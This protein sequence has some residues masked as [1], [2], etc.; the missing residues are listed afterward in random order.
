MNF[1]KLKCIDKNVDLNDYLN[2]IN[3]LEKIC[4]ILNG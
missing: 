1:D 4:N 2:Y 3:M